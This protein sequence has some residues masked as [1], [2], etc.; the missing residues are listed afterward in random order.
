MDLSQYLETMKNLPDRFSSLA[1]WRGVRK[2]RDK[3]VNTFEY[4]G[5]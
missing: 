1:F 2:L 5:E 4:V 3:I